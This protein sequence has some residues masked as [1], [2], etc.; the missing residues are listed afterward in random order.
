[1]ICPVRIPRKRTAGS[2]MQAANC[3]INGLPGVSAHQ[4]DQREQSTAYGFFAGFRFGFT[5][6]FFTTLDENVPVCRGFGLPRILMSPFLSC[7]HHIP[8]SALEFYTFRRPGFLCDQL[9]NCAIFAAVAVL[10]SAVL[11][12]LNFSKAKFSRSSS[13]G[14]CIRPSASWRSLSPAGRF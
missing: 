6:G 3:A 9:A 8:A 2:D 10:T 12:S 5:T 11:I 4:G 14:S 1:M 7:G 13:V